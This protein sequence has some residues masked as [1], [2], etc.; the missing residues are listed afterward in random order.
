MFTVHCSLFNVHFQCSIF[1]VHYSNIF[2]HNLNSTLPSCSKLYN[3]SNKDTISIKTTTSI[4]DK[5]NPFVTI[6]FSNTLKPPVNP[7]S[8]GKQYHVLYEILPFHSVETAKG[9]KRQSKY[10]F[11]FHVG[12]CHRLTPLAGRFKPTYPLL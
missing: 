7:Q 9:Q 3:K 6:M 8:R 2:L 4:F 5:A 11:I 12:R 10:D 1:Y